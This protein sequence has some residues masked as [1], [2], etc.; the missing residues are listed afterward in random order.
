MFSLIKRFHVRLVA[1]PLFAI[2]LIAGC[3]RIPSTNTQ[4]D[5]DNGFWAGR[6]SLQIQSEPAQSFHAGFELKGRPE[7]GELTLISPLGSILG[8]L[9]W[10]PL[11]AVLDSG[12]QK[13][14]R[15][16]SV[17]ALMTQATGAAIPMSALF[18]WLHGDNAS[19]SGWSA[20]LSRQAEGRITAKRLLPAPEADLRLVLDR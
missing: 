5:S 12:D 18:A 6:I 17:E 1:W 3:A 8:V 20:D 13:I 14:Q 19:V 2:L 9:R 4:N 7:R 11:E 16:D 15:F 10:S